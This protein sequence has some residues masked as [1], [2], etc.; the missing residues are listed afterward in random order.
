MSAHNNAARPEI[1]PGQAGELL[2]RV[3]TASQAAAGP[4]EVATRIRRAVVERFPELA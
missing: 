4:D 2:L 1:T 3:R